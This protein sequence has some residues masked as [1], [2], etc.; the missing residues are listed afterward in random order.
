[1][2]GII[3]S[4]GK[5]SRLAPITDNYPKQLVPVMGRP[6]LFHCIENLRKADIV[7]IQI[8]LNP[9]TGK[10]IEEKVRQEDFGV[11]IS[12]LYQDAP[13]GLA[14]AVGI[15]RDFTGD[16]D[17]TVIL[18][19]NIFDE[20]LSKMVKKFYDSK[21]DSLILI[22]EVDRPYDF[23]VVKFGDDG[24]AE[25][26]VEK[27]K[28]FVS[29]HAIVGVYLFSKSIYKFIDQV[30][31]SSRGELEITDAISAQVEGGANVTTHILNS[32]WF[33]SGTREGLLD[34]NKTLLIESN[35][36]D[37]VDS[38]VRDS[39]LHGNIAVKEKTVIEGSN[40]MGP[41]FIGKNV[42][43]YNSTLGPFTA[44][45]DNCIIEN[46]EVQ[47]SIVMENTCVRD[48]SLVSSVIHKDL[49]IS[50]KQFIINKLFAS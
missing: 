39:Y 42:R 46:S 31:P 36:F 43:I 41:I 12:F 48:S 20:H 49:D 19:D 11:N 7:D 10:I 29:R 9:E 23:G 35:K 5:G 17:F 24:K 14:H 16:D 21:A 6:I 4:G 22:K 34:A 1:M 47:D 50:G 45:A 38:I 25:K 30:K 3:L 32:Y 33:D 27:P 8:V 18:G 2:K 40:L 37:N 28:T 13:R 26:L 15:N 44:I